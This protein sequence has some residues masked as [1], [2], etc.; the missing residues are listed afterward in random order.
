MY[1][2]YL[3]HLGTCGCTFEP[4]PYYND[5]TKKRPLEFYHGVSNRIIT[6]ILNKSG[7]SLKTGLILPAKV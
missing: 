7:R 1:E 3:S 2:I 6:L 5:E 4:P